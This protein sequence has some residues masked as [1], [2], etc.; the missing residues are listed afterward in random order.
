MN[1]NAANISTQKVSVNVLKLRAALRDDP[2][3]FIQFFLYEHLTH[4]VPDFHKEIFGEMT[5]AD[6]DRLVIAIPR[7]HA[8]TTLAKLCCAWYL[9]FSQYRFVLYVSASHDLVVPYVNDIAAFF[10]S[11][12]FESV[13]GE[14][15]WMKRQEG[16]GVYKFRI[17]SLNKTCL[18]RGLGAG[19]RVRG[20]NID[21]ERPQLAVVDDIED[22]ED[23]DT[24]EGHRKKRRWWYGPFYKCLNQFNNKIIACGNLTSKRSVLWR[25]LQSERWRSYLYGCIRANKEP[26]WPDLWP[27]EKLREDYLEYEENGEVARWFAEMMNQPVPEGGGLIK[28]EEICYKPARIPE[29]VE[30]GFIT[31]DPAI[32]RENWA[33]RA[34]IGAHIWVAEEE[35][36]QTV[37]I[38]YWRGIDPTDLFFEIIKLAKDWHL[39][40]IGV[41]TAAF[42]KVLQHHFKHLQ[43]LH[44]LTQ[45]L[46]VSLDTGNRRKTERLIA[47]ASLLKQTEHKRARWALTIG[48]YVATQQLLMYEPKKRDNDDDIIDMCAY[49]VQ[50]IERYMYEIMQ[51]LEYIPKQKSQTM[52]E[53]SEV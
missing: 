3:M 6:V 12:N 5:H 27:L 49:G 26:L 15:I 10:E 11:E 39:R 19:Q 53:I 16:N 35:I 8:K 46:F 23:T 22:D 18:L 36:W 47:W 45:F 32:S 4:E 24:E 48:D 1:E 25:L 33:D 40:V 31:V 37:E 13:F 30:Y 29:E 17:K 20:I 51:T 9:I 38:R 21:H 14:V 2:E 28:A 43:L 7:A 41:E 34:A 44:Q 42:Q 52:Y 50:M